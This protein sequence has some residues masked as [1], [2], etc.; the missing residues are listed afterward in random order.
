MLA[1]GADKLK[2]NRGR[3]GLDA[4]SDLKSNSKV[5][6]IDYDPSGRHDT[7]MPV[8]D[9][10]LHVAKDLNARVLTNDFNLNKVAG[11][12]GVDVINLNELANAVKPVVL[13]GERMTVRLIKAGEEAG[14]GV[15][16]LTDGTMVVVE[17]ARQHLNEEVEFTV[18]NTRQ[19]SAGKMIFGRMGNGVVA[20][21]PRRPKGTGETPEA[22]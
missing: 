9:Q 15:G 21:S 3:H 8:D 14:Q 18:T 1:D 22:A 6:V 4:L 12:R 7:Q 10:L 20:P 11:L 2:R 19:T 5:D 13:P 17:Q 16:F